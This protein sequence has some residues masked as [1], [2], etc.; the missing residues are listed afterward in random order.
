[1]KRMTWEKKAELRALDS[2][3]VGLICRRYRDMKARANGSKH[4]RWSLA[5]LPLLSKQEFIEWS[6]NDDDYIHLYNQWVAS[7]YNKKASPSIH[8]IDR[9]EGYVIGNMQWVTV[10]AHNEISKTERQE[11]WSE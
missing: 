10:A 5:G 1:M 9:D 11:K 3:F 7:G 4:K 2:S 6:M 8:R